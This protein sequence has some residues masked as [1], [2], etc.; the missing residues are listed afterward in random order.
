MKETALVEV[1]FSKNEAKVYLSLL[2]LGPSTAGTIAARANIHRTNVYDALE[3][4]AERGV[5]TYIFKG[6]KKYFEA[7]DPKQITD[8]LRD[9]AANFETQILPSLLLDFKLSKDKNKAHIFEGLAGIKS[10]TDDMLREGK[11]I[12]AFGIPKDM[13]TRIASFAT[14]FHKKRIAKKIN[15]KHL[16]DADARDRIMYL[17]TLPHTEAAF[18]QHEYASPATTTIYGEKV[19]FYIWS[20]PPVSILIESKRMAEQYRKY[21]EILW[22]MS[23]KR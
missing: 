7:V 13:A 22:K 14:M 17:N 21:F 5:T 11:D 8:A 6:N 12:V 19:A 3:R 23:I 10:I 9:R 18:I 16:Y 15:M 1:G 2:Q 4:L 20:D